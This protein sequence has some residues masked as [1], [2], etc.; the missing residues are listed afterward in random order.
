MKNF[1]DVEEDSIQ[2]NI[3]SNITHIKVL[4]TLN[5]FNMVYFLGKT[6]T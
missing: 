2:T 6:L 5:V 3:K 1:S 4:R